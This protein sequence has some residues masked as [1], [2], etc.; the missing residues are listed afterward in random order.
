MGDFN[1]DPTSE[2]YRL[3]IEAGFKSAHKEVH[4]SE[5]ET[6]FPTGLQAEFMDTDPAMC[7]DYIFYKGPPTLTPFTAYL[8]GTECLESDP[9]IY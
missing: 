2:P 4:G 8:M 5:P 9:T 7:L 6:T 3:F 1:A